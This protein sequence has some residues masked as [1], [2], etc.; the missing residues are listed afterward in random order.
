VATVEPLLD[1]LELILLLAVNPGWGG[2]SFIPSTE[3]RLAE[4]RALIEDREIVV[5]VDGGITKANAYWVASLGVDM[6]VSGSA[7]Y[8]GGAPAENA[9]AML[10][11]LALES[12]GRRVA[13][14]VRTQIQ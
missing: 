4:V 14:G 11:A 7:I 2:Q 10:D 9:R 3:R 12:G 6:I 5:A 1:E 13:A 8:D